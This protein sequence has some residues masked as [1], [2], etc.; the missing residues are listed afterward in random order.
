MHVK[1]L[2]QSN[3]H[4]KPGVDCWQSPHCVTIDGYQENCGR[5][6]VKLWAMGDILTV[7]CP[8]VYPKVCLYA[9]CVSQWVSQHGI[10]D[11]S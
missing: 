2:V 3:R 8:S 6:V 1:Y 10:Q 11:M 9:V 4:S 5:P 7:I